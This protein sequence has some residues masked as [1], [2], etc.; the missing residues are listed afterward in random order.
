LIFDS[1]VACE[2]TSDH[3]VLLFQEKKGIE[4]LTVNLVQK[5]FLFKGM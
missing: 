1:L 3:A 4:L 2:P 5:E